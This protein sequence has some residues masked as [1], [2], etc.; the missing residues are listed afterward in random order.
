[1]GIDPLQRSPILTDGALV[2]FDDW[3]MYRGDP[4]E[5]EARALAEFL[6]EH[7]EWLAIPYQRYSVFCNSFILRRR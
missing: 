6:R 4:S 2:C 5:G 3:F 1:M 7:S